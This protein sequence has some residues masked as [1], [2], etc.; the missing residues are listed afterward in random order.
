LAP[1]PHHAGVEVVYVILLFIF[2]QKGIEFAIAAHFAADL[3][4]HVLIPLL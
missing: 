2:W 3:V 4:L 1:V